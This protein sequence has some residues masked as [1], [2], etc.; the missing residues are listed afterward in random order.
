MTMPIPDIVFVS[1]AQ[2]GDW[3]GIYVDGVLK[4]QGHT[5]D[6]GQI[7]EAIGVSAR[8]IDVKT[9]WIE[10]AGHLPENLSD[11]PA[12]AKRG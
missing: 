3:E 1:D 6:N 7:L 8:H 4:A 2:E 12:D 11:I 10:N 5:L 9:E